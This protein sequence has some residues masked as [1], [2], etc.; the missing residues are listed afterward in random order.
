MPLNWMVS[1]WVAYLIGL[2]NQA[3][4]KWGTGWEGSFG[5]K[6]SVPRP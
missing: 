6:V 3:A 1:L 4:L 2:T 5:V